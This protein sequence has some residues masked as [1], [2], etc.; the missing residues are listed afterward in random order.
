MNVAYP[1]RGEV[2][3]SPSTVL[4][5]DALL[6][7]YLNPHT[8]VVVTEATKSFLADVAPVSDGS[9]ETGDG[10]YNALV[11]G[12]YSSSTA[13]QSESLLGHPSPERMRLLLPTLLSMLPLHRFSFRLTTL[14]LGRFFTAF[15]MLMHSSRI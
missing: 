8:L 7:K 12:E 6:L 14:C 5:D 4:G 10:F 3:Q 9:D 13:G 2:I 11:G 15:L 1:R